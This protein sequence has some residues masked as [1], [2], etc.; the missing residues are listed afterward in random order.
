[1]KLVAPVVL[2]CWAARVNGNALQS[3]HCTSDVMGNA[4][5]VEGFHADSPRKELGDLHETYPSSVA[6][7]GSADPATMNSH[8]Y[9]RYAQDQMALQLHLHARK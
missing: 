5:Y 7:R 3:R 8:C 4:F 2:S 9:L 1:M 6:L